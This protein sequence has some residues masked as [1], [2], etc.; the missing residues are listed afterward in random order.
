[1]DAKKQPAL[2]RF[3]GPRRGDPMDPKRPDQSAFLTAQPGQLA[4]NWM[5]ALHPALAL[6]TRS[7]MWREGI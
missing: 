1:M 7:R 3:T 6:R 5:D 2:G 4:H